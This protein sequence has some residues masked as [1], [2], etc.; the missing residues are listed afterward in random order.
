MSKP[1]DVF[2]SYK[3]EEYGEANN[4]RKILTANG[5]SC[6]MA[7]ESIPMGS[8]YTQVI[9]AAI[10]NCKVF[11]LI[12]SEKSQSSRWV[13]LELD[14]AMN[15]GK[16]IYPLQIEQCA[17]VDPFNFML[18]QTQRLSMFTEKSLAMERLV[19]SL[20]QIL[21]ISEVPQPEASI[22]PEPVE[23]ITETAVPEPAEEEIT[24]TPVQEPEPEVTAEKRTVEPIRHYVCEDYEI[25]DGVL[26]QYRGKEKEFIIPEGVVEIA[27]G[28][29]YLSPVERVEF[30]ETLR[31]IGRRA[32]ACCNLRSI[33]LPD[34]ITELRESA[35]IFCRQLQEVNFPQGLTLIGA[36]CFADTGIRRIII[37]GSVR[38]LGEM[39]FA[40]CVNLSQVEL[41]CLRV[42]KNAFWGCRNITEVIIHG[43]VESIG[44][45]A[46]SSSESAKVTIH[47][48]KT[49]ID[50]KA[51]HKK[52]AM[53]YRD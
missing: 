6:W 31:V 53:D 5:I 33:A 25:Q 9:P 39:A 37:P 22:Q 20:K 10:E 21:N 48:R 24:E 42:E 43:G 47:S 15:A 49:V 13:A 19:G 16:I 40:R 46:F 27:S 28:A 2:I 30:P 3:S 41:A 23:E 38:S 45:K 32:F 29:F 8:N 18:S 4:V 12:L 34:G 52:A 1:A 44:K 26:S 11:L 17:I 7:P 35:F 51:F 14:R 36:K 50:N